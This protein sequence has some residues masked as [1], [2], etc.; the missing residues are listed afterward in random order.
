MKEAVYL[1][2]T[3]RDPIVARDGRPFGMGQGIRMR[4]LD[5]PYP[6][7]L[8][9]SLRTM[10][11]K[12]DG[13]VFDASAVELLKAV[14]ISGPLPEFKGR[15]YL[16]S[17]KDILVKDDDEKRQAYAIRPIWMKTGED[18]DLPEGVIPAMLPE[19]I[20]D[21]FKPAK[22]PSFWSVDMMSKWLINPRGES[23]DAP[24]DPEK[25]GEKEGFLKIPE[26]DTRTHVKIDSKS[27]TSEEKMLFE[28]VGL[29][30]SL[31]GR[32]DGIQL[33]ARVESDN[34]FG[35]LAANIGTF[36]P[37]GG[38]RRLAY[39]KK[40]EA[41][42]GWICPDNVAEALKGKTRIR[43]VLA[44][45]AIFSDGW[46]PGWLNGWKDGEIPDFWPEGLELRLI[47][48]CTD[49]W[50]PISGWSLERGSRGPKAI[51]R[52]V[53]SG[54]VYFFEIPP[55]KS[56]DAGEVAKK[57]WMRSVS[58]NDRDRRDGFGLAVWGLWD[59]AD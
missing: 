36:H 34:R 5:W 12:M 21:E 17:P 42:N 27:G 40:E 25:I 29:D 23:F 6:S 45:P 48:A 33:A 8:A 7:V 24:P 31:K 54:S 44:T 47:S 14:Q 52:L 20:K 2:I 4:S 56:I 11:G 46:K 19:S 50:K 57:L 3:P 22:M 41:Q 28:T 15:I 1:S 13:G 59:F 9:G 26:K 39:W 43:M 55:G 30:L 51:R 32:K 53:P 37:L 18:C 16:P 38:E 35:D 58:D 49:R 10:L